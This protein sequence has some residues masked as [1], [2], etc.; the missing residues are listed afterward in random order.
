MRSGGLCLLLALPALTGADRIYTDFFN[1]EDGWTV[2]NSIEGLHAPMMLKAE[3]SGPLE[4]FFSAPPKF[5]GDQSLMYGGSLSYRLGFFSYGG[6]F[7]SAPD[8]Y[9]VSSNRGM[10][11]VMRGSI[12]PLSF[13]N[14]PSLTLTETGGWLV[15]GTAGAPSRHDFTRVLS[16][17]SAVLIRGGHYSGAEDTYLMA[18]ALNPPSSF[19][20]AG[21][22]PPPPAVPTATARAAQPAVSPFDE[23][24]AQADLVARGVEGSLA[25]TADLLVYG[26]AAGPRAG[27]HSCPFEAAPLNPV[28]VRSAA[29]SPLSH[30]RTLPRSLARSLTL[31]A[32]GAADAMALR[33]LLSHTHTHSL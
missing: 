31:M 2:T 5:L 6:S 24:A 17:L 25:L 15:N 3:D 27:L 9:L 20:G 7:Q 29:I 21:A 11:L 14:Q 10:T 12:T 19:A 23:I 4:W 32:A 30:T 18:V 13:L 26:A 16:S 22:D 33:D 8:T 1:H 28:S